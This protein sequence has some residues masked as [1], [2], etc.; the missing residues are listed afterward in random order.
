MTH[1]KNKGMLVISPLQFF[2]LHSDTMILDKHEKVGDIKL[3]LNSLKGSIIPNTP[4]GGMKHYRVTVLVDMVVID[5]DL[6]FTVRYPAEEDGDAVR[7]SGKTFSIVAGFEPGTSGV[8]LL[9]RRLR[10][11]SSCVSATEVLLNDQHD[12]D[13]LAKANRKPCW[14]PYSVVNTD[15]IN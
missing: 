5:R 10:E 2:I 6:K 7:G 12:V 8:W 15:S 14:I 3:D 1:A 11:S 4:P 9:Q 13:T